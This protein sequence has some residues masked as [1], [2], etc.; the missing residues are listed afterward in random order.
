MGVALSP[1]TYGGSS[2]VSS[3]YCHRREGGGQFCGWE[4]PS[5]VDFCPCI[6][7]R[8]YVEMKGLW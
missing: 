7:R 8:E 2:W 1:G 4:A 6:E 3:K 5:Y